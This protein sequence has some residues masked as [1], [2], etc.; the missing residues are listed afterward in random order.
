MFSVQEF[1]SKFETYD[2]VE[3]FEIHSNPD[4][5]SDEA[6]EA[7]RIVILKK[8][9]IDK[10]L[11]R[12]AERQKLLTEADKIKKEVYE[13]SKSGSDKN[14]VK[15]IITS[16]HLSP[17]AVNEIIDSTFHAHEQEKED[18]KIKPRTIYGSLLGGAVASIISGLL[19]GALFIYSERVLILMLIAPALIS[20]WIIKAFT[21]QSKNN[22]VILITTILSICAGIFIGLILL[23]LIGRHTISG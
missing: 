18:V 12:I 3:L 15:G 1:V 10:L 9:G 5:Y 11:T 16:D 6:K 4:N 13:L 2:D 7:F 22:I 14:F 8:G 23:V 19:W 17:E 20:Y 21:K